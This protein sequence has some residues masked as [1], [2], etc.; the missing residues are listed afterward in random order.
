MHIQHHLP[1]LQVFIY[2]QHIATVFAIYEQ[3]IATVLSIYE[4]HI[5]TNLLVSFLSL[6]LG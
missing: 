4:R 3:H 1:I 5:A 6:L 2:K